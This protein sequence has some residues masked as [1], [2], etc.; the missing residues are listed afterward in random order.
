MLCFG[1]FIQQY[2]GFDACKVVGTNVE[3]EKVL[4]N[5][6]LL[7][8]S[9]NIAYSEFE[10]AKFDHTKE[11]NRLVD[12][13]LRLY[14]AKHILGRLGY[15]PEDAKALYNNKYIGE[16]MGMN[17]TSSHS[18]NIDNILYRGL[19]FEGNAVFNVD[20]DG[21]KRLLFRE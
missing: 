6:Y 20:N 10:R 8:V 13:L 17:K 14:N 9:G 19:L 16:L 1:V 2:V 3:K 21:Q 12:R 7:L 4:C 5:S 15:Y 11:S 18:G